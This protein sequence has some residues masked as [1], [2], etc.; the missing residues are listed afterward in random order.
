M[1]TRR[2]ALY[3]LACLTAACSG[4]DPDP[5]LRISEIMYHPTAEAAYDDVAEFVEVANIGDAAVELAG[6]RLVAEEHVMADPAVRDLLGVGDRM[7]LYE[8]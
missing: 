4:D 1:G 5:Q 6:W 2:F 7:C 8:R 3:L